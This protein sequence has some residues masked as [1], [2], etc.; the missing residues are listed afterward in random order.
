MNCTA[1][2]A[3]VRMKVLGGSGE[4]RIG[5]RSVVV[6]DGSVVLTFKVLT[7]MNSQRAFSPSG[8]PSVVHVRIVIVP[9]CPPAARRPRWEN[10]RS[11]NARHVIEG[12]MAA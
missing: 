4:A 5:E 10:S 8:V 6:T 7:V 11:W 9:S 3:G 12:G 1:V 2:T